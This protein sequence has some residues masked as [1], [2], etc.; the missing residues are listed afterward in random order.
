MLNF[1]IKLK[2]DYRFFRKTP[3]IKFDLTLEY[4]LQKTAVAKEANVIGTRADSNQHFESGISSL[5]RGNMFVGP[6]INDM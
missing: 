2:V 4:L 6:I 1:T 3:V 5:L